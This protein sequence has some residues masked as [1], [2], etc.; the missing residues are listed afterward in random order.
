MQEYWLVDARNLA[1]EAYYLADDADA[2]AYFI[3]GATYHGGTLAA[4][5]LAGWQ[6]P[7]LSAFAGV[8]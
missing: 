1:I 4:R 3:A 2:G 6:L 8:A 5:V 7:V